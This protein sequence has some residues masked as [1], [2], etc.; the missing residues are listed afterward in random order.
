MSN[1]I[2]C[3]YWLSNKLITVRLKT[4]CPSPV[5]YQRLGGISRY[6]YSPHNHLLAEE[7]SVFRR[8]E[9]KTGLTLLT[10]FMKTRGADALRQ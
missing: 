1:I 9:T 3:L 4:V 2:I 8:K 6:S 10:F 5:F 7:K